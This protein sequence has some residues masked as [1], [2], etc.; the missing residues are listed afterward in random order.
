MKRILAKEERTT[1]SYYLIDWEG[2]ALLEAAW[3]PIENIL[4]ATAELCAFE[5]LA[6][7]M[8]LRE[9]FAEA[10]PSGCCFGK[11]CKFGTEAA[12]SMEAC[13]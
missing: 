2:W 3:E 4:T 9:A 7:R 1:G 8:P 13:S 5:E 12:P 11:L 10:S 6:A